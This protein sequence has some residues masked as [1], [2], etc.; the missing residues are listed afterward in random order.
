MGTF[1]CYHAV[2]NLY[3]LVYTDDETPLKQRLLEITQSS[4]SASELAARLQV[5]ALLRAK[6]DPF[7]P[8]ALLREA[9]QQI[10][11]ML[12]WQCRI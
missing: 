11:L 8:E 3:K 10:I 7:I 5:E 1:S 2:M 6:F 4:P 12:R 9:M